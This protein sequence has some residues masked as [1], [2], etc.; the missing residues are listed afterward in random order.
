[1]GATLAL[2][3]AVIQHAAAPGSS[4]QRRVAGVCCALLASALAADAMH[5]VSSNMAAAWVLWVAHNFWYCAS[6]EAFYTDSNDGSAYLL[7][8][9]TVAV[10]VVC[11]A[12]GVAVSWGGAT[13]T[14]TR[15]KF[16][17]MLCLPCVLV[18]GCAWVTHP[19][20]SAAVFCVPGDPTALCR[21]AVFCAC[22]FSLGF[23]GPRGAAQRGAG[24][25]RTAFV[26]SNP[27]L[28]PRTMIG[29][30][31]VACLLTV[32]SRA[33]WRR[34][35]PLPQYARQQRPPGFKFGRVP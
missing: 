18:V 26:A 32:A 28:M 13:V 7:L 10:V 9:A 29:I 8:A 16:V 34:P 15:A 24:G 30:A 1:M 27:L 11:T 2:L 12:S 23:A 19:I 21:T 3:T 14:P 25:V 17:R 5:V 6:A 22:H 20:D 35:S 4:A 33:C 31:V